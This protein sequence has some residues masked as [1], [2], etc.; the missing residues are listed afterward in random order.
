MRKS[1]E[2]FSKRTFV[3]EKL[4]FAFAVQF[5]VKNRFS[6]YGALSIICKGC[7]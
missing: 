7:E 2:I 3:A 4:D 6:K 1:F 5:Y